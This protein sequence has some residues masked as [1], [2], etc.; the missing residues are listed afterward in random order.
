MKKIKFLLVAILFVA[1]ISANA[2]F[3]DN[4]LYSTTNDSIRIGYA[5]SPYPALGLMLSVN[6]PAYVNNHLYCGKYIKAYTSTQRF[7]FGWGANLGANVEF[8]STSHAS[9]P[10]QMK[11][12]YGGPGIGNINFSHWDG[13][14]VWTTKMLI[15]ANGN[16][17]I[18]NYSTL[19]S[20]LQ[21]DGDITCKSIK[22][23]G[24]ITTKEIEVTIAASAFPDYVFDKD[25]NLSPLSEVEKY[26]NEHKHL[27]GIPSAKEVA[28]NGLSLGDM[29]VKLMEKV[30]ELT[31]YVIQLQKE[32]DQLNDKK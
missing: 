24:K 15:D 32:I 14:S 28:E 23:N 6:G 10:G 11:F 4:G 22:A 3:T 13:G 19:S 1:G 8:Y 5:A 17:G 7:D 21:V 27:Q 18:G 12:I 20:K 31:L 30:E 25:Y 26:I 16:V 29:N 2:Q 9:R